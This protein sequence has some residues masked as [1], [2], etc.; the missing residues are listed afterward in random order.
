MSNSVMKN[1]FCFFLSASSAPR[2]MLNVVHGF[3]LAQ[4]KVNLDMLKASVAVKKW[5]FK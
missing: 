3:D 2:S 1:V 5:A 4:N